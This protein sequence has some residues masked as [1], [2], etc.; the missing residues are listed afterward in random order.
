MIIRFHQQEKGQAMVE[1]ALIMPIVILMLMGIFEF[2]R[3]FHAHIT[4]THAAREGARL[5]AVG[6]ND[7]NIRIRVKDSAAALIQG[8]LHVTVSPAQGDRLRGEAVRVEVRYPVI[9]SMPVI[10]VAIPNP[11]WVEGKT[12]MRLE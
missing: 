10:S 12:I 8:N 11:V 3:L 4:V 5:A 2:G 9:L 1:L 6:A 7:E